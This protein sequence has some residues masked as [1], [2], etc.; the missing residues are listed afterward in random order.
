METLL[1]V[2][3]GEGLRNIGHLM[4]IIAALFVFG[5]V[6]IGVVCALNERYVRYIKNAFVI[7]GIGVVLWLLAIALLSLVGPAPNPNAIN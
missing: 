2:S 5:G 1:I 4:E 3:L 6:I 7:V